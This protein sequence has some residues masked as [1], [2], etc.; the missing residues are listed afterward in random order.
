MQARAR[1]CQGTPAFAGKS[2][3]ERTFVVGLGKTTPQSL[4]NPSRPRR[5]ARGGFAL[6]DLGPGCSSGPATKGALLHKGKVL[7][8]SALVL[9]VGLTAAA[10][11]ASAAAKRGGVA[12]FS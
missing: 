4:T 6:G 3:D 9:A 11:T 12:H 10:G 7:L 8:G 1:R 2:S 5:K